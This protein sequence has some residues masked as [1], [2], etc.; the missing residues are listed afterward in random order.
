MDFWCLSGLE[1]SI[2]GN[3]FDKYRVS[4]NGGLGVGELV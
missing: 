3:N 1:R 4:S 2:V